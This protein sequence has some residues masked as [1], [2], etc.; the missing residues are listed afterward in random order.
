[1]SGFFA[2]MIFAQSVA[3]TDSDNASNET[4]V[5]YLCNASS[6][7]VAVYMPSVSA[8]A[9]GWYCGIANVGPATFEVRAI[10]FEA[11]ETVNS[12]NYTTCAVSTITKVTGDGVSNFSTS[13]IKTVAN[14]AGIGGPS[15]F[16]QPYGLTLV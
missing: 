6:T 10:P 1:V 7:G 15:L 2:G 12:L 4:A 13:V 14:A 8:R 9:A 3:L 16:L 11:N 5:L